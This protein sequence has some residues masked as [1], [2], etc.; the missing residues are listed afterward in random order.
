[1]QPCKPAGQT[2]FPHKHKPKKSQDIHAQGIHLDPQ[3]SSE[4]GLEGAGRI[5]PFHNSQRT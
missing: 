3:H 2:D 1:M 5:H 4:L